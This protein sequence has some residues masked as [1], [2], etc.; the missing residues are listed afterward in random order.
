MS[1]LLLSLQEQNRGCT[2]GFLGSF[3]NFLLVFIIQ[4]SYI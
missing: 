2:G 1:S 3:F 4:F